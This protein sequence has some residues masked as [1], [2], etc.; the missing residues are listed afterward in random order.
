MPSPLYLLAALLLLTIVLVIVQAT[1]RGRIHCALRRLAGERDL[2]FSCRDQLRLTGRVAEHL[3]IPG[4]AHVRVVDLLYGTASGVHR[5]VFTAEYTTGIVRSKKR[6][7][8][9]A[10][11]SEPRDARTGDA[12]CSIRLAPA[13]LAVV[14]QY[15]AL[16]ES[17]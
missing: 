16:L 11:F 10:T 1:R 6:V 14:D 9:V 2:H 3:P 17:N 7:R 12:P 13:E 4:A 5:Y 8:R 15:R